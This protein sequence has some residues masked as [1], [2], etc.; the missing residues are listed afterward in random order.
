MKKIII[1]IYALIATITLIHGTCIIAAQERYQSTL[2]SKEQAKD[3]GTNAATIVAL[4][5]LTNTPS[6]E[7]DSSFQDLIISDDAVKNTVSEIITALK[8]QNYFMTIQ[9]LG[10][11]LKDLNA[12]YNTEFDVDQTIAN[13]IA[14]Q[15]QIPSATKEEPQI[16][17]VSEA[18]TQVSELNIPSKKPNQQIQIWMSRMWENIQYYMNRAYET[19]RSLMGRQ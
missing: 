13:I 16:S 17:P 2:L 19:G 8:N 9:M 1:T 4:C 3:I 6:S 10:I 7:I 18:S 5:I 15:Q 12:T 11:L 14:L